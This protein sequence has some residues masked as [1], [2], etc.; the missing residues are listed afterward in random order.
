MPACLLAQRGGRLS[1]AQQ[2]LRGL[3]VAG[4]RR[5]AGEDVAGQPAGAQDRLHGANVPVLAGVR[6]GHDRQRLGGAGEVVGVEPPRGD[7]RR[8]LERLG[9]RA[10]EGELVGIAVRREELPIR[11]HDGN[12]AAMARLDAIA[13]GDLDQQAGH[14]IA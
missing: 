4:D 1:V 11:R 7:E 12:R 5:P 10:D 9:G 6:A 3:D 13:A 14:A 2:A 8:Q